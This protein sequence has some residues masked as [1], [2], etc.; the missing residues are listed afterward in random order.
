M[1]RIAI[2]DDEINCSFID[3]IRITK[4]RL[5]GTEL[6]PIQYQSDNIPEYGHATVCAKILSTYAKGFEIINIVIMKD[7]RHPAT[8]EA[9]CNALEACIEL[10]IELVSMS[11]RSQYLS[12][13][14]YLRKVVEKIHKKGIIMVS[15]LSNDNFYTVPA[16][17]SEVIGV[18]QEQQD[19]LLPGEVVYLTENF[20]DIQLI[21][22]C[23]LESM[24][25]EK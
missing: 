21:A 17:L 20:W 3:G 2:I 18:C 23:K 25:T 11:L 4:Y 14:I 12:D 1:N 16:G 8:I 13:S 22:N 5:N 15:A 6:K 9:L 10:N 24:I 7:R 19:L